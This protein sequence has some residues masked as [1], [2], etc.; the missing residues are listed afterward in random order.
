MYRNL[1]QINKNSETKQ[2]LLYTQNHKM[3]LKLMTAIYYLQNSI[4]I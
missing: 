4:I 2:T 1:K 3:F